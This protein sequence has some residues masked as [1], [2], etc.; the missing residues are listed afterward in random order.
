MAEYL[1]YK[2]IELVQNFSL[3]HQLQQLNKVHNRHVK[4]V[5]P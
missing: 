3:V 4:E 5:F 1:D 2:N